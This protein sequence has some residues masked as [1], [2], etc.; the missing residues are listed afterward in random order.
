MT[1]T[2]T[3]AAAAVVLMTKTA[4]VA[5]AA[6]IVAGTVADTDEMDSND[7]HL[8]NAPPIIPS[9]KTC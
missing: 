1:L 3:V 8:N 4:A 7:M 6:D 5:A 9:P 2:A